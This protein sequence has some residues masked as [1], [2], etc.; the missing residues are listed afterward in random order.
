MSFVIGTPH[1][2]NAGYCKN[3]D[4]PSGGTLLEADVQTCPHCQGVILMQQWKLDGGWCSKCDAPLCNNP[5]C[6]AETAR[7]GC[8][9]FVKKIEKYLGSQEKFDK[10]LKMA[11]LEPPKP[12]QP[13]I[14]P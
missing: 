2:H 8:V 13:L 1:T 11:G 9:P 6:V 3:D 7:L 5:F 4:R 12:Q 14:I 10:Y